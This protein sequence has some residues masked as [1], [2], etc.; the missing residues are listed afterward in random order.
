[1]CP[2]RVYDDIFC[3]QY[4]WIW[5]FCVEE[6]IEIFVHE[7]SYFFQA[8]LFR[9]VGFVN[10]MCAVKIWMSRCVRKCAFEHMRPVKVLIRLR[11][12]AVW[13]VWSES[14]LGAFRI[15]RD[16]QFRQANN[17][18]SGLREWAGWLESSLGARV[19]RYDFARCGS[20]MNKHN[21]GE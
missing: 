2:V 15:A 9:G 8:D 21:K 6:N 16:A 20:N 10:I 18:D 11:E 14:S 4:V 7:R 19:K 12:C 5:R 17:E 1:M 13:S 3:N